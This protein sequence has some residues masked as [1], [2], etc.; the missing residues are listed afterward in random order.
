M[1]RASPG[2]APGA[3]DARG[4]GHF[5]CVWGGGEQPT[6]P[7]GPGAPRGLPTSHGSDGRNWTRAHGSSGASPGVCVP[8]TIRQVFAERLLY[9]ERWDLTVWVP[10]SSLPLASC[11]SHGR[12]LTHSVPRFFHLHK[13]ARS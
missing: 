13:E 4:G 1:R 10:I 9:A 7:L 5:G 12:W 2:D 6:C 8:A 11:V 3:P